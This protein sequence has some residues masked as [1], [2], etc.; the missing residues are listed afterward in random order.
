MG[1]YYMFFTYIN[2]YLNV[3]NFFI[4]IIKAWEKLKGLG[5]EDAEKAYISKVNQLVETYGAS[6]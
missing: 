3:F 2:V 1:W 4:L 6:A 5:R